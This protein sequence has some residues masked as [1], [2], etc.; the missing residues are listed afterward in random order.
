[1]TIDDIAAVPIPPMAADSVLIMW[2]VASMVPEAYRVAEAWGFTPKAELVWRKVCQVG[3]PCELP[4]GTPGEI[5]RVRIGMGWQVRM[6]HEA[7]IIATRGRVITRDRSIPSV[8]DAP[9][10]KHSAKPDAFFRLVERLYPGPYSEI[11]ARVQRPGW[12]CSGFELD[13]D[14][15]GNPCGPRW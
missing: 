14:H 3:D 1:M 13:R 11:F 15:E 4:D 5:P 8:F 7:A 2:R 9:S 12:R 10:A 6:A